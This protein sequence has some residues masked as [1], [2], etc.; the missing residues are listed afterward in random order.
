MYQ[1]IDLDKNGF[2]QMINKKQSK[3]K[4]VSFFLTTLKNSYRSEM[5][6]ED[7]H[8]KHEF[9]CYEY[10]KYQV[11]FFFITQLR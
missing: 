3:K 9:R 6:H 2:H 10:I 4:T 7:T 5:S 8:E 11:I 1:S